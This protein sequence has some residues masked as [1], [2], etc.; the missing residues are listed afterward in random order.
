MLLTPCH[1]HVENMLTVLCGLCERIPTY[2]LHTNLVHTTYSVV[3]AHLCPQVKIERHD[4][5]SIY[6][7]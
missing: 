4:V 7:I 5:C 3:V 2:K 6:I 1:T